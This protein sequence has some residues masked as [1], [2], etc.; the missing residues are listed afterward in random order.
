MLI[1]PFLALGTLLFSRSASANIYAD[2]A[3][4]L[5]NYTNG[6]ISTWWLDF[7][8][9]VPGRNFHIFWQNLFLSLSGTNIHQFWVY[10]T[11]QLLLYLLVGFMGAK[12]LIRNGVSKYLSLSVIFLMLLLPTNSAILMWA[13]SLP[14][15]ITSTILL[16]LFL[17]HVITHPDQND[18]K[19]WFINFLA[20]SCA[21]LSLFTYDQSAAVVL[22]VTFV[23]M[24]RSIFGSFFLQKIPLRYL[25]KS[26][27][28]LLS[29]ASLVYVLIFLNGRGLGDNLTLGSSSAER[30]LG[31]LALPIKIFSKI[32]NGESSRV[33]EYFGGNLAVGLVVLV[34][35][36]IFGA[37]ISI[38]L[39]KYQK[40]RQ[41]EFSN[42]NVALF[43]ILL[44]FVAFLPAATWYV[45]PRHTFLPV[46][47]FSLGF[48][49]VLSEYTSQ[50]ISKQHILFLRPVAVALVFGIFLGFNSQVNAWVDRDKNRQIFYSQFEQEVLSNFPDSCII[51]SQTITTSEGILYSESFSSARKFYAGKSLKLN[52]NGCNR[53]PSISDGVYHCEATPTKNQWVELYSFEQSKFYPTNF[54]FSMREVCKS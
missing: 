45:A 35:L 39:L 20:V 28:Y 26:L 53:T 6:N 23:L 42:R 32:A 54:T 9:Y 13:S 2:D 30:L 43:F 50:Y 27:L 7:L 49:F 34:V 41:L 19:S 29:T 1:I 44:S 51:V 18:Q 15:H 40:R 33:A 4:F 17:F 12:F 37:L 47:L 8:H 3:G 25:P 22:F 10:H 36:S 52:D 48:A 38:L 24:I 11:I 21:I 14:M 16:L 46:V 5:S 31:N